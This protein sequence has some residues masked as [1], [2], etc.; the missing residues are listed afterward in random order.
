MHFEKN[1]KRKDF[2]AKMTVV[3]R[4]KSAMIGRDAS[5]GRCDLLEREDLHN[6]E[7]L[8]LGYSN[9]QNSCQ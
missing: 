1:F 5:C 6:H 8:V 2:D 3:K 7:E 9:L 4:Q